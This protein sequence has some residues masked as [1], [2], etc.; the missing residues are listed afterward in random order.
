MSALEEQQKRLPSKTGVYIFSDKLGAI[1]YIGKAKNLKERTKYYFKEQGRSKRFSQ[2]IA[3]A[4]QLKFHITNSEQE[5]FL[6]EAQL[7]KEKQPKYNIQYK[8][9]RTLYYLTFSTH[10]YPRIEIKKKW[11]KDAIGPFLSFKALNTLLQDLLSIFQ[12]R[13]CSDFSFKKRNRP[14]L[15][16]FS[17]KCSG[18]CMQLIDTIEYKNKVEQMKKLFFGGNKEIFKTLS[19]E[20]KM[21]IKNE[22]FE[23]AGKLQ[24]NISK[25]SVLQ[26][27]QGI[28]FNNVTRLDIVLFYENYFYVES[29][30]NGAII[31]IEYRKYD[32]NI[33]KFDILFAFYFYKPT[34]KLIGEED[35]K[36]EKYSNILN[37][38]EQK[39]LN[40]AKN[41]L[42]KLIEEDNEKLI[43]QMELGL[44]KLETI[45][46]YDCSHYNGQFN[47]CGMVKWTIDGE[48][49]TKE[50]KIWRYLHD[51]Y[52]DLKVLRFGLKERA[53]NGNLPDL[54]L[55]DGGKTQL[56][57]AK[58][59]LTPF[60]NII[61]YAKGN[62]RKGGILYKINNERLSIKNQNLLYFLEN[63]RAAAHNWSK[64]N[65]MYRF[66]S[67]YQ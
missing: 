42:K 26:Q 55:I 32:K 33:D 34:F 37:K 52:D 2:M 45:E 20:L 43:W 58:T 48:K 10:E 40:F 63:I 21:H 57:T 66:T 9:G 67:Q 47:L 61:A 62:N 24:N 41:R 38:N 25:L 29:I 15:E 39:M 60:K 31:N 12:I 53:Q 65:A 16:Y 46:A 49:L 18:P 54:I 64:K 23:L 30:E 22:Q 17:Q 13:T 27:E 36:F 59:A 14:C 5:A 8:L 44:S 50:Y 6:L 35:L 11:E 19:N 28:F 51:T 7:I 1:L 56:E 3:E 4:D